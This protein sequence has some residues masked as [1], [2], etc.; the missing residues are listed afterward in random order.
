M[1]LAG[2]S[3][4]YWYDEEA[5]NGTTV[6]ATC[7]TPAQ[8]AFCDSTSMAGGCASTT[9]APNF[10]WAFVNAGKTNADCYYQVTF[11]A[12]AGSSA[13]GASVADIELRFSKN[14]FSVYTQANDYSYNGA[15]AY[16]A[17]TK[18]TAYINS[19]TTPVLVYGTEPM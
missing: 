2:L 3:L 15:T 10:S 1:P 9:G 13:P 7:N 5:S 19:T 18:V 14:D 8:T 17:T 11:S 4:R 12:T 16:T 6:V